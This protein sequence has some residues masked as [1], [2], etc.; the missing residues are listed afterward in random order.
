MVWKNNIFDKDQTDILE[1]TSAILHTVSLVINLIGLVIWHNHYKLCQKNSCSVSRCNC[2]C[3]GNYKHEMILLELTLLIYNVIRAVHGYPIFPYTLENTD[4]ATCVRQ[5]ILGDIGA[6][7]SF[8]VLLSLGFI[9]ITL[10]HLK[11]QR[12]C[13]YTNQFWICIVNGV[14]TMLVSFILVSV[15]NFC[16]NANAETEN[17]LSVVFF[18]VLFPILFL[19]I[20]L[21]GFVKIKSRSTNDTI[22]KEL[23]DK[24]AAKIFILAVI[25]ILCW[26]PLAL[27]MIWLNSNDN[28]E[29]PPF[30]L[31]YITV[32]GMSAYP[33]LIGLY[34]SQR[35]CCSG[36]DLMKMKQRRKN[37]PRPKVRYLDALF[38]GVRV[39]C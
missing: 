1:T 17:L 33:G 35:G 24:I 30:G 19:L 25:V 36:S 2:L 22:R 32:I 21:A 38:S 7:G 28:R 6:I 5:T 14:I 16:Q 13:D 10:L 26:S 37:H 11:D 12:R 20:L 15:Q 23:A 3:K 8:M 9:L 4:E 34:I 18:S 31:V 29:H 27:H 39:L